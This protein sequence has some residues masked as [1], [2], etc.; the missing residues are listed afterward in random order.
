LSLSLPVLNAS[1]FVF[2]DPATTDLTGDGLIG[3]GADLAPATLIQAYQ[4]GIFPWFNEDEPIAWWSP[5]IRA[6]FKPDIFKAS[7]T[8]KRSARRGNWRFGFNQNFES[9]IRQ[10]ADTRFYTGTWITEQMI[11]AYAEL[12][13]LGFAHSFE[14]YDS[15]DVLIGG[16]YG[17]KIGKVF[18]GE[19]MFHHVTDASKASF[20]FMSECCQHTGIELID[21]QLENPHL[22]SLGATLIPKADFLQ[23]LSVLRTQSV[24]WSSPRTFDQIAR[25]LSAN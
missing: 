24:D 17:L 11:E 5:P 7:R 9:V 16:I 21:A 25:L 3:F 2:P 18:C 10:C 8:L 4:S 19:S 6:V 1:E 20:W 15:E 13:R 14:V 23:Q 12:H 22:M